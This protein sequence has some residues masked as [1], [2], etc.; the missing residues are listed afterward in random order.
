M[1]N[2]FQ[3]RGRIARA[4]ALFLLALGATLLHSREAAAQWTTTGTNT[5]TTNNV[6]IGT[7]APE[8]KLHVVGANGADNFTAAPAP[9]TLFVM[10]GKGGNGNWGASAG[11]IGGALKLQ[12]GK[13]GSPVAG[14]SVTGFGGLGGAV[15][16]TGG[17]GGD[18]TFNTKAGNG[19][20]VFINGGDIGTAPV[21]GALVGHVILANARGSVGIGTTAPAQKLDVRGNA[22][23]DPGSSPTLYTGTGSTELNRYLNLINSPGLSTASGLKAGGVLVS[24]TYAYANPGKN[25]LIVKGNVGVGTA[26]PASKLHV[27]GDIT[28]TGNINAK[29]QDL[30][31]WVPSTQRLAAGTVVVL[32]PERPNHVLA[33]T[34]S[35]D[36]AVAGVV[37]ARPG[38][39]LG[40]AGEGKTLVATTGRVK[41]RVDATRA[42]IKIG[43][44]IVT[45]DVEGLAMKS[46]PVLLGGRRIHAPGTII[47]KALEP[48]AGGTGEILVLLS[49]Q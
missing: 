29:Y 46:E 40:E 36:T 3:H 11:G 7:T 49:L 43:D 18:N 22:I 38:I 45:S 31:E 4:A 44:L 32:D 48:L 5:T 26:A 9:D 21:A 27:V 13:G 23:L 35:Y 16:I 39:A 37:S 17:T 19:G 10:G 30:A 12:G 20:S 47:G 33:S 8:A 2:L 42:P 28:V 1:G 14:S 6:G 24:D 34:A 25:D 15:H 41:V